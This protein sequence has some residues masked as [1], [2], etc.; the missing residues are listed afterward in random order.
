MLLLVVVNAAL[1]LFVTS[2]IDHLFNTLLLLLLVTVSGLI[3]CKRT[4]ISLG[5]TKLQR[6]GQLWLI[7]VFATIFILY[8]GW[9]PQLDPSS[10]SS[11]GYDSQRYYQY[12][13]DLIL[14][15]WQ[16]TFGLNYLG[17]AYYYGSIFALFG[18]N[19][20]IPALIN[21][22]VTLIGILFLIRSLYVIFFNRLP[23]DWRIVYLL[24]IPEVLW[25]D[26]M[27]SRETLIA[28]LLLAI[29]LVIGKSV[30]AINHRTALIK[31]LLLIA[32]LSLAIITT[33]TSLMI[34]VIVTFGLMVLF[35]SKRKVSAYVIS[36]FAL[37]IIV[38]IVHTGSILQ[39][40]L[41]GYGFDYAAAL[42]G[43]QSAEQNIAL[44]MEWWSER[45]IGLLL[46]PDNLLQAILFLPFRMVLYLAAP[47]PKIAVSIPDLVS[48]S[49]S[50]WQSLMTIPTSVLMLLL[51]PYVLAGTSLAWTVRKVLPGYLIVPIAF[52]V[53]FA[54]VAGGN[55]IIHE[56][57]RLMFTLPFFACDWIGYT[58]SK[59]VSVKRWAIPWFGFLSVAALFYLAYKLLW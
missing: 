48:G 24:L 3:L 50:A 57:Y 10:S 16:P 28:I 42:S 37:A 54:A 49:W 26:V 13:Y 47:L 35:V 21:I 14:N 1:L 6:L 27:T 11:W 15:D 5:D 23:S 8:L 17:I 52:W 40:T 59:Q 25:Y 4:V 38:A 41:G 53:N 20:F 46:M 39:E 2:G 34:S 45:S 44:Q 32:T 56:R 36:A 19:P 51:F 58:R 12:S 7:K 55:L 22:S 18:R 9:M 31:T 43:I 29:S 30:A 33:R